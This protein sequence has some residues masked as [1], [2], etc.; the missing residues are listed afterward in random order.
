MTYLLSPQVITLAETASS[1]KT[2]LPLFKRIIVTT[3]FPVSEQCD[4][5]PF[6][7]ADGSFIDSTSKRWC[8]VSQDLLEYYSYGDTISIHTGDPLY[9]GKYVIHDCMHP[10]VKNCVD[11]LI[12]PGDNRTGGLWKGVLLWKD[13]K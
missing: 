8:A 3:Y 10:R 11:I 5:S 6:Y 13:S 9:N 12:G 7:T 1:H 4:S 2:D